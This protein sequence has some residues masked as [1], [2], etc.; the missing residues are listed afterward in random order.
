MRR[1]VRGS[2][3]SAP[4]ATMCRRSASR[5][6]TAARSSPKRLTHQQQHAPAGCSTSSY[7]VRDAHTP[8]GTDARHCVA[9]SYDSRTTRTRLGVS[10]VSRV[11]RPVSDPTLSNYLLPAH[12]AATRQRDTHH[13]HTLTIAA[14]DG[15][16]ASW[17][18]RCWAAAGCAPLRARGCW[19][20][21]SRGSP[22]R[23]RLLWRAA[24]RGTTWER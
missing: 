2:R 10:L 5:R 9:C 13:T 3:P 7:C 4:I 14:G 23:S 19:C 6:D 21:A 22:C 16:T 18:V 15:R 20:A 24:V 1:I 11:A 12:N 17:T 8:L